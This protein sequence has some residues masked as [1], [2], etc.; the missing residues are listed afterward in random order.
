MSS[1]ALIN[2]FAEDV[3]VEQPNTGAYVNGTWTPDAAPQAVTI[4]MSVQPATDKDLQIL[5]EGERTR[6]VL[7]GYTV[8]PLDTAEEPEVKRGDVILYDNTRF[9]VHHVERWI[10]DL[11]HYKVLMVETDG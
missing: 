1:E 10:G 3:Q 2:D 7:K 11:S 6:R 5:P 4:R 9:E 8:T